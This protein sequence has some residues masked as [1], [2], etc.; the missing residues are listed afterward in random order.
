[1]RIKGEYLFATFEEAL[2]FVSEPTN[3]EKSKGIK[4][5][6]APKI[7]FDSETMK[8]A[9][10]EKT[11]G[12]HGHILFFKNSTIYDIWKFWYLNEQQI[13]YLPIIYDMMKGID[14]INSIKRGDKK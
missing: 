1:M 8:L 14:G 7:I 13:N 4:N 3:Y 12:T 6:D 10:I 9:T 2:Q 5:S 11:D